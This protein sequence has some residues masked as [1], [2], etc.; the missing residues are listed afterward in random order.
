[1]NELLEKHK[2]MKFPEFPDCDELAEWIE[3]LAEIEGHYVGI[4]QSGKVTSADLSEF[5]KFKNQLVAISVTTA[6]DKACL[7]YCLS[8]AQV[9]EELITSKVR[10]NP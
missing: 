3:N 6:E 9:L 2:N 8:Y 10:Q 4:V 1:M 5:L 7:E